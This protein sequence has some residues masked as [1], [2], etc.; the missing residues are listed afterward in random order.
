IQPMWKEVSAALK[1]MP[2]GV[3]TDPSHPDIPFRTLMMGNNGLESRVK[4]PPKSAMVLE[5]QCPLSAV[6]RVAILSLGDRCALRMLLYKMEYDGPAFPFDLTRTTNPADVADIVA[7]G[8]QDMWN[9]EWLQHYKPDE[10]RLYHGKWLGL[11]F[12]H[13][14]EDTDDPLNDMRPVYERMR[15]RY[16]ARAERFC[17]TVQQADKVLFVRTAYVTRGNVEDLL[18]KLAMKRQG[19]PF[20]LLIFSEQPTED[21]AGLAN[22]LHYNVEFNPDRMY[23]DSGYWMDCTAKMRDILADL[24]VSSQNLFWCPPNP[25]KAL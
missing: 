10:K 24:G 6:E 8:F 14:V 22:V 2:P 3:Y 7:S 17:Y 9:P 19:K 21:F 15:V 1:A 16:S 13:E 5:Y 23:A 18:E 11:S 12:G 4:A 20:S 25:P